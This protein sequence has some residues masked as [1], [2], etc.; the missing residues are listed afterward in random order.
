MSRAI[1]LFDF[2]DYPKWSQQLCNVHS[3][4]HCDGSSRRA[5][6]VPTDGGRYLPTV[7]PKIFGFEAGR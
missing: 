2:W 4:R 1:R 6:T 3:L 5:A 7:L